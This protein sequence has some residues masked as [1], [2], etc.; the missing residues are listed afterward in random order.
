MLNMAKA[1]RELTPELQAFA[2]EFETIL[3]V[4]TDKDI[5][6]AIYTVFR[7]RESERVKV[8]STVQGMEQSHQIAVVVQLN[9]LLFDGR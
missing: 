8:Y 4:E 1:F 2:G 6:E 7:S 5:Q 3:N 9:E